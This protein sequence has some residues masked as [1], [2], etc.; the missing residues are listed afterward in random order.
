MDVKI[1][2]GRAQRDTIDHLNSNYSQ[3]EKALRP[4]KELSTVGRMMALLNWLRGMNMGEKVDLDA[5]LS[6][7]L[8]ALKT[9]KKTK[10][11][12]AITGAAYAGDRPITED[13][14]RNSS[15]VYYISHLLEKS[16]KTYTDDQFLNIAQQYFESMNKDDLMPKDLTSFERALKA[17]ETS[18]NNDQNRLDKMEAELEEMKRRINTYGPQH[19]VYRYNRLIREHNALV[20]KVEE[21][22]NEYNLMVRRLKSKKIETHLIT[23]IGGGIDLRPKAFKKTVRNAQSAKIRKIRDVK[24]KLLKAKQSTKS[25]QWIRNK[26]QSGKNSF[27]HE[28][29]IRRWKTN[30]DKKV[31]NIN[32]VEMSITNGDRIWVR[33]NS[34]SGNWKYKSVVNGSAHEIV[35]DKPKNTATIVTQAYPHDIKVSIDKDQRM[36]ILSSGGKGGQR[37]LNPPSWMELK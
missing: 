29:P 11:I 6:V 27:S 32:I 16:K 24:K 2:V 30:I 3:Y 12:L 14:V 8:P 34:G 28:L 22:I 20:N 1:S 23:S 18:I 5:L 37:N 26:S 9:P 21:N 35:V 4:F 33:G 15:K 36:I 10:K 13:N 31:G 25:I 7:V 19:E 17:L